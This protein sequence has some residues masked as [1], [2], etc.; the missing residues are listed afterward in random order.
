M[1]RKFFFLGMVLISCLALSRSLKAQFIFS[2]VATPAPA[3]PTTVADFDGDGLLDV[4]VFG[5]TN[6]SPTLFR[7][8]TGTAFVSA[9]LPEASSSGSWRGVFWGDENGDGRLD[10]VMTRTNATGQA[11]PRVYL[12]NA[13]HTFT[14]Q[15]RGL[16]GEAVGWVDLDNDGRL[17]ILVYST[18]SPAG[19]GVYWR[20]EDGSYTRGFVGAGRFSGAA[21]L[22]S[23]G[24]V[25]L[26]LSSSTSFF[27][28]APAGRGVLFRN[29]G[30]RHFAD[31]GLR[32]GFDFIADLNGDGRL[33]LLGAETS[34][35]TDPRTFP[36]QSTVT[37]AHLNL[38]GLMF[39]ESPAAG[40]SSAYQIMAVADFNGDGSPDVLSFTTSNV[41]GSAPVLY[42]NLDGSYTRATTTFTSNAN[43][44]Y[45]AAAADFDNDG[46]V[47]VI[48]GPR[49]QTPE[50]LMR[51]STNQAP[52]ILAPRN[53]AS[54]VRRDRV[55][56]SWEG[57]SAHATSF[58]LRVGTTPGGNEVVSSESLAN[59]KRMLP[60]MGNVGAGHSW[61]VNGL[62]PGTYFWSV[63]AVDW[64]YRGSEFATE[65]SFT[66]G[67]PGPLPA[68]PTISKIENLFT[69]E[70]TPIEVGFVVGSG[71]ELVVTAESNNLNLISPIGISLSGA[72]AN[73]VVRIVPE[74]DQSG[75]AT[76][77]L[78]VTDIFGQSST[79]SFYVT[80]FPVNDPPEFSEIPNQTV[81]AGAPDLVIPFSVSDLET[82]FSGHTP[83]GFPITVASSDTNLVPNSSLRV[84]LPAIFF[85][86][87]SADSRSLSI[88]L[89]ANKFGST[90]ITLTTTDG[91]ATATRSFVLAIEPPLFKDLGVR[92]GPE[93][94]S[95]TPLAIADFDND[96]RMDVLASSGLT[97]WVFLNT[98]NGFVQSSNTLA[99][100]YTLTTLGDFNR[101]NYV[102]V[103]SVG[104][105]DVILYLNQKGTNFTATH[106]S[107]LTK[108]SSAHVEAADLDNDGDL[109]LFI[110]GTFTDLTTPL[111]RVYLNDNGAFRTVTAPLPGIFG[112]FALI[113]T[114]QDGWLDVVF[115]GS[116]A[117]YAATNGIMRG[118]GGGRFVY[119]AGSKSIVPASFNRIQDFNADGALDIWTSGPTAQTQYS[120]QF[121]R[122]GNGVLQFEAQLPQP[123]NAPYL[124]FY[125]DL[126]NDG[127]PEWVFTSQYSGSGTPAPRFV[128]MHNDGDY[129][130]T[131]LGN[132]F[133]AFGTGG[134]LIGDLNNDDTPDVIGAPTNGIGLMILTNTL[135]RVNAQPGVPRN[136]R[137]E[138]IGDA[139]K[140]SWDA[141]TDLDQLAGLTYNVRIGSTPGGF[142]VVSPLSL[143]NGKRLVQAAGNA[144][145]RPSFV[146]T[147][148]TK[149]KYY[150]SVQA[151]DNDCT[152]GS[153]AAEQTVGFNLP[154]NLPPTVIFA[155]SEYSARAD[156]QGTVTLT[157]G[158][159]T[160][161]VG[162]IQL[163][164]F[165]TDP[166]L[167]ALTNITVTG[168]GAFR[169]VKFKPPV[170]KFGQTELVALATDSAGATSTN[171]MSLTFWNP[172]AGQFTA[173]RTDSGVQITLRADAN[174]DY[175]VE[176]SD[177][178]KIWTDVG[179]FNDPAGQIVVQAP[180]N[181]DETARFY[182]ARVK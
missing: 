41:S 34:P 80:V 59:G 103:L 149:A 40:D 171:K 65:Q 85:P 157:L 93:N 12:Q 139:L 163:R 52:A 42:L 137:A 1:K 98:T 160:T 56:F 123:T 107:G 50:R 74:A 115:A 164:V 119:Q 21:D 180:F 141:P 46:D 96:G 124:S 175:V 129:K 45:W 112:N 90:T 94:A 14:E 17:D 165:A 86:I 83:S 39:E 92:L 114:D 162:E 55:D 27:P 169:T 158:D 172:I 19:T 128:L 91:T 8:T 178:L 125:G 76:V 10:F 156:V 53:L 177:D 43:D 84:S 153:F 30:G 13:D 173:L 120:P 9:P 3:G 67:D 138:R 16:T 130:F 57:T 142:D 72:G 159:D 47:D 69:D 111:T 126:D 181:A 167:L 18:A 36:G 105:D 122:F 135:T 49:A 100:G 61:H 155:P 4:M 150:W 25:D 7:N 33:D 62:K 68:P 51:N 54:V 58:N 108:F 136:L 95:M 145:Y 113:D 161:S 23:D 38:G 99:T 174:R 20:E 75:L 48:V 102:D 110:V 71:N 118:V 73:R 88:H 116:T 35:Q 152:G 101:D 24:D 117:T 106:F 144:G 78:R 170:G 87:N 151:V 148:L 97:T 131:S 5:Q 121:Y 134:H 31:S 60:R 63:Q 176:V 168:T 2:D 154:G 26:V 37:V 6:Y 79:A 146:L 44:I 28:T 15:D 182:R 11:S 179:I 132:P 77:T 109:D 143:P 104:Q 133:F 70:D 82:N 22:D 140:F 81:Y 147:N 166:G 89:P 32:G 64:S 29:D 127:L 66:V